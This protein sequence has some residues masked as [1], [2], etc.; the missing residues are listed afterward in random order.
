MCD[1]FFPLTFNWAE[2]VVHKRNLVGD[3][4]WQDSKQ[5]KRA[6]KLKRTKT[7]YA[8]L[9]FKKEHLSSICDATDVV[10]KKIGCT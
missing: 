1:T 6:K 10:L 8:G 3:R 5:T 9:Y 4:N 2:L 7:F